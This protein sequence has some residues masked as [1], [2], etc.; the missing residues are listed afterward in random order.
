[1]AALFLVPAAAGVTIFSGVSG[2]V[3]AAVIAFGAAALLYIVIE[4]L[5]VEAHQK[6]PENPVIASTFFIG[7]LALLLVE[8]VA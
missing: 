6:V 4:E 3:F 8:M 2:P 1:M 5:F 7:F